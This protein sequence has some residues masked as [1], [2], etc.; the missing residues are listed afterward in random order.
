MTLTTVCKVIQ[1]V[2]DA[3][4]GLLGP[5]Y[6]RAALSGVGL[7]VL[8]AAFC[9]LTGFLQLERPHSGPQPLHQGLL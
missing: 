9:H 4:V 3:V 7:Q 5:C 8:V 1:D 6:L 2:R